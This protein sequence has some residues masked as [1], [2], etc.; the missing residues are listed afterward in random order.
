MSCTV[1][2][3]TVLMNACHAAYD[4]VVKFLLSQG[5]ININASGPSG[6]T[7]LYYAVKGNFTGIV[8]QLLNYKGTVAIK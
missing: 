3:H 7:A 4:D 1:I 8:E 6:K 5:G 2:G